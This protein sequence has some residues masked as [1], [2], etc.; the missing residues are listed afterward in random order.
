MEMR[1]NFL[2][3]W[4]AQKQFRYYWRP[5]TQNLADYFTKHHSSSHHQN[6]QALYLTNPKNPESK[7]LFQT[8]TFEG[9]IVDTDKYRER[10]Q[11]HLT[12]I[13]IKYKARVC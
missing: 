1:F 7:K 13:I 10:T 9:M 12:Q 11:L 4:E 2:K 8:N 5:G 6:T 3:C